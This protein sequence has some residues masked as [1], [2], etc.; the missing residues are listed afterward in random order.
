MVLQGVVPEVIWSGLCLHLSSEL[1]VNYTQLLLAV[2]INCCLCIGWLDK[3]CFGLMGGCFVVFF[4][5]NK[6]SV[7]KREGSH[8]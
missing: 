3:V 6:L 5:Y 7:T 4:L 2:G 8:W 1:A